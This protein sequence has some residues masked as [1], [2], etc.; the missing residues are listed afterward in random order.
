MDKLFF[1][2]KRFSPHGGGENYM[3]TLISRLKNDYEITVFSSEW[4]PAEG[5]VFEKVP[6]SN[7]WSFLSAA[8]FNENACKMVGKA[9][10]HCTISFER[11]TCQD[12]YR[13]GEGCHAEWLEIR[14]RIEPF[15]K[16]L[17]F[18]INPLHI[19]L[20]DL[21][22]RLF[23][24]TGLIIA[25]S[26]MV[27][28][29]IIKHYAVPSEKISIIYNGVDLSRF[30]PE[31]KVRW[32]GEIRKGLAIPEDSKVLLFVGSGFKRKG[33][34]T[35]IDSL[36]LIRLDNVK[37]LVIGK[38]DTGE[39]KAAAKRYGV[40]DKVIFLNPQKEIERFYAAA[41]L[42][43]LPTLYDPFSNATLEAMAAGIPVITTGNNGASELI[44]D[45]LEGFTMD[46]PLDSRVLA[47]KI[48]LALDDTAIMGE[49][50]RA[51]AERFSIEKAAGEFAG[52]I[53]KV[54]PT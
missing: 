11:T 10:S 8:T 23:S 5:V 52:I 13:A 24:D 46:D 40:H 15:L 54:A 28:D 20:L 36:S 27:K 39:Y 37:V 31:N 43:V 53:K 21:E 50:A 32:R 33:L 47:E 44:E 14:S 48:K 35:F 9:R 34:K 12:I 19:L 7:M 30:S 49:R 16:R 51:R 22:K 2:K 45:G 6:V 3:N 1:I 26:K 25:N 4:A 17:S 42:F 38:G 29:N 41:D 18:T